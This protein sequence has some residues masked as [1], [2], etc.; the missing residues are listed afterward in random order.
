MADIF[1]S[2]AREDRATVARILSSL[3]SEGFSVW[4]DNSLVA[5]EQFD[6]RTREEIDGAACMVVAWSRAAIASRYVPD[7][8]SIGMERKILV[9]ISLD[10]T[11]P[12]IG[13]RSI[14]AVQMM[15]GSHDE[16]MRELVSGIQRVQSD[17]L[18]KPL[19]RPPVLPSLQRRSLVSQIA[20][21]FLDGSKG[22]NV[23]IEEF[24]SLFR[25]EG[26]TG[27]FGIFFTIGW[28]V[29]GAISL[30]DLGRDSTFILS[31]IL[32]C[33]AFLVLLFGSMLL[34]GS[35]SKE[36]SDRPAD[37]ALR[38]FRDRKVRAWLALLSAGYV[39]VCTSLIWLTGG[40]Y[41]PF[42]PFY[43][44][45]FTL[46]LSRNRVSFPGPGWLI[47]IGF[48]IAIATASFG[49]Y[50]VSSPLKET[51]F[52]LQYVPFYYS[53]AAVFIGASLVV[54]TISGWLFERK[55]RERLE[56]PD[57]EEAS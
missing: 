24:S 28:F 49:H 39:L 55:E 26:H 50:I 21:N 37:K 30:P 18:T 23:P 34:S 29:T 3:K 6:N 2:Y 56:S 11:R 7:E 38:D 1:F 13:F 47:S 40:A 5:G 33:I 43:V 19:V 46:T 45:I 31:G 42:I 4:W 51:L 15:E 9:P 12:P 16:R 25:M 27:I 10:G 17:P 44:M 20:T 8:A 52:R 22:K 53:V 32:I 57:N 35:Y 41:S 36:R 54:P 48:L 14:H